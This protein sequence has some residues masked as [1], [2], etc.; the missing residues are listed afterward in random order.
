[1]LRGEGEG[2]ARDC[3]IGGGLVC[4]LCGVRVMGGLGVSESGGGTSLCVVGNWGL[5][6]RGGGGGGAS[7]C[8]LRGEDEG[9]GLGIA[10]S[11]PGCGGMEVG[12]GGGGAIVRGTS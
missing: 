6:N 4:M 12:G 7:L 11:I 1:M 8:V 10:E 3:R 9:G 2:G 5:H